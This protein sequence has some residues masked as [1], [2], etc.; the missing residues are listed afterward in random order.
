MADMTPKNWENIVAKNPRFSRMNGMIHLG[1]DKSLPPSRE[2]KGE[3][4]GM[5][6]LLGAIRRL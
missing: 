6:Y 4:F 3:W 5:M 2:N 1:L